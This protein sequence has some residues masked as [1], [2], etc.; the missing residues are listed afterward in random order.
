MQWMHVLFLK[1][2]FC[3]PDPSCWKPKTSATKHYNQL[4]HWLALMTAL[5]SIWL[6][7][8]Y[9]LHSTPGSLGFYSLGGIILLFS[10]WNSSALL[11]SDLTDHAIVKCGSNGRATGRFVAM[12][13]TWPIKIS[14][15]IWTYYKGFKIV[16]W[17]RMRGSQCLFVRLNDISLL[18]SIRLRSANTEVLHCSCSYSL[19]F[20][21]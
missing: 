1:E 14:L 6:E 10:I 21:C 18:K 9:E 5:T 4:L 15:V 3:T 13:N 7:Q 20:S 19:G 12:E 2:N 11:S 16:M 17:C 8:R